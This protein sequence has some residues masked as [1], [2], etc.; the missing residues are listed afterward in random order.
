M[1]STRMHN[2]RSLTVS[3]S[4]CRG[5]TFP[6]GVPC[7]NFVGGGNNEKYTIPYKLI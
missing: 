7:P 5:G 1:H 4:I 6:G 2:A 3:R